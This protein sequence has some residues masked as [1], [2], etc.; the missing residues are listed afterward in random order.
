M[1]PAAD[2]GLAADGN[3]LADGAAEELDDIVHP[4]RDRIKLTISATGPLLPNAGV[5]LSIQGAARE[6][7]DSGEV[8]LSLPTKALMDH[9]GEGR[10]EVPVK[11]R[12]E[13]PSMA[14]GDT[15]SGSYTVPGEVAGYYQVA[16]AAH[17]HGPYGGA[18]LFDD[19]RRAAWM[20]ISETDRQLTELFDA[21]LFPEGVRPVPGPATTGDAL[22][23]RPDTTKT[24]WHPDS[25]YLDVV[26]PLYSYVER[27]EVLYSA[28]GTRISAYEVRRSD[29]DTL[30][31]M[32]ASVPEDGIVAFPCPV[33]G[34]HLEGEG[35]VYTTR[36]VYASEKVIPYWDAGR[37]DC[38][39]LQIVVVRNAYLPWLYLNLAADTLQKHFGHTRGRVEYEV[40]STLEY[41][42]SYSLSE[43]KIYL[44]P[45]FSSR[46]ALEIAAHEY[47]HALHHKALGGIWDTDNCNPHSLTEPSSYT[48][49][50]SEGFASYAGTVGSVIDDYP[51]GYYGGCLEHF[52]TPQAPE[53]W[54]RSVSHD[55]KPEIE[56]WVAALFMDLIDDN[57]N[58]DENGDETELSGH[59]VATV[60]KTCE[61]K[62]KFLWVIPNWRDRDKV[63]DIVWC[64]ENYIHEPTHKEVFDVTVPEEVKREPE[65]N[66]VGWNPFDI[67]ITWLKN[68]N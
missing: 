10:P 66:P 28:E 51:N 3:P 44:Y 38:G 62:G 19:V 52:G 36:F 23:S 34:A 21:S 53:K 65:E 49:A 26:Y 60:F 42:G 20:F 12:W 31:Y 55:Q 32:G 43:D 41:L 63:S 48:C 1:S 33:E 40:V 56:G 54:C 24:S 45:N 13:L 58:Y 59:F 68:L 67:R 64:L 57:G 9:V 14:E 35:W 8:V 15:W 30:D 4:T 7:I 6:P 16:V 17:T 11:A 22:Y 25:V 46:Q 5:A 2:T 37:N 27:R 50:L 18:Y 61:V 29:G 39:R 47:G